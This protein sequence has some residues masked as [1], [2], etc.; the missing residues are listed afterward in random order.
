MGYH[1]IAAIFKS[2]AQYGKIS[3]AIRAVQG[4]KTKHTIFFYA[5]VAF[6]IILTFLVGKISVTVFYSHFFTPCFS[7]LISLYYIDII[8]K[9]KYNLLDLFNTYRDLISRL[10]TDGRSKHLLLSAVNTYAEV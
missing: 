2:V 7:R 1:T 8:I 10:Y 5:A 4:A 6:G 3:L 9:K